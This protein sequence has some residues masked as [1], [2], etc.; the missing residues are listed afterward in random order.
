M[1][2]F[3]NT[4]LLGTAL[5]IPAVVTTPSLRAEDKPARVYHDKGRN[6]DHQWNDH[7]DRA[8]RMW[9]KEN[10]RK[11]RDFDKLKE[12]EQRSYWTWRHDHSDAILKIDVH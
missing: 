4:V 2:R 9:V 6:E 11:Y 12:E 3:L 7:E 8:Y 5:L 1:H 10:H